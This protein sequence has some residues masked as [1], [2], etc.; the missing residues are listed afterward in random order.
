[1]TDNR[2]IL[3]G[4]KGGPRIHPGSANPTSMVLVLGGRP[5]LIDA[6]Y[7][8]S[9]ALTETGISIRDVET[10]FITHHHSDHNLELGTFAY[11]RWTSAPPAPLKIY[12]PPGLDTYMTHF[13]AGHAFDIDIR[14]RDEKQPD[15]RDLVTW[16]EFTE[17][18]VFE[19]G[20]LRVSALRVEHPPIHHCYALK[21]ETADRTIVYSADTC[22]FEPLADFARGADVLIHEVMYTPGAKV[23]CEQIK[24]IKPDLWA[25]FV[26]SHTPCEDVGRI[27]AA[28]DV[29]Q[30]V[31]THFVP[32]I[33]PL[34]SA[35]D[36]RAAVATTYSG[37]IRTGHD[38]FELA[39]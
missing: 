13:M 20:Q 3:L 8:V 11:V 16:Q 19:N 28:A 5:Y 34:A 23:I 1:M 29:K 7:G 24:D 31:L 22:Y 2:L 30:L 10:V 37:D 39:L 26:A 35:E 9:R 21:F 32:E 25:H 18:L 4:T 15:I 6:G 27:A 14:T 17:G 38:G 33:G 12:G 36:F